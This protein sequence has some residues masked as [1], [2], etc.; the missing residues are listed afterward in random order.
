MLMDEF[1]GQTLR[2]KEIYERH[3][4]GR[5]YIKRNYKDVLKKLDEEGLVI[6]DPP[7][8]AAEGKKARR[9]GSFGDDVKVQFP[10]RRRS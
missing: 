1:A 3:N 10:W 6:S 8:I 5:R 7:A 4:V 9:R 2:M